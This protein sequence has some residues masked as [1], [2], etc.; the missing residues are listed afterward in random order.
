VTFGAS[1]ESQDFALVSTAP[2]PTQEAAGTRH[3][4][5]TTSQQR[6]LVNSLQFSQVTRACICALLCIK[7]ALL[8]N[9]KLSKTADLSF[10]LQRN[11]SV[12]FH[13]SEWRRLD[14]LA[15]SLDAFA[16][17]RFVYVCVCECGGGQRYRRADRCVV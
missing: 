3:V 2:G 1:L 10:F 15:K 7:S 17:G 9:S 13:S 14:L 6:S 11:Y 8:C 16:V 5:C 12:V 4:F